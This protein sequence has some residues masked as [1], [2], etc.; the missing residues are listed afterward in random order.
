MTIYFAIG[1]A[2]RS[3]LL[4]DPFG[5]RP[6]VPGWSINGIPIRPEVG[7]I[8][9]RYDKR[10]SRMRSILQ[11]TRDYCLADTQVGLPACTCGST[12]R[13]RAGQD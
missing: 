2:F 7:R 9:N 6:T 4:V 11:T 12:G 13:D 3:C 10:T 1:R 8:K 5:S